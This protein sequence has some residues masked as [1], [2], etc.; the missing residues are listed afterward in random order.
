MKKRFLC[1]ALAVLLLCL[2]LSGCVLAP[3]INAAAVPGEVDEFQTGTVENYTYSNEFFGIGCE[4]DDTWKILSDEEKAA[5][6]GLTFDMM[7]E[8]GMGNSDRI[9]ME[10]GNYVFD[11][12]AQKNDNSAVVNMSVGNIGVL[13]GTVLTEEGYIDATTERIVE[14]L[15]ATGYENVASE[16]TTITFAGTEHAA[17]NVYGESAGMSIYQ[18]LVAL[19]KGVYVGTVTFTTANEDTTGDL[20]ALFYALD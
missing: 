7:E 3:V 11:F 9:A 20:A 5:L 18:T 1:A 8:G 4:L 13:Y 16:K 14:S 17:L 12:F 19:R 10:N 2:P 6:S 15:E